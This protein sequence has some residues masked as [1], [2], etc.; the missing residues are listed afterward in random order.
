MECIKYVD[1]K[2]DCLQVFLSHHK[3]RSFSII[4]IF[5]LLLI[6]SNNLQ[7]LVM[8]NELPLL[9]CAVLMTVVL[10]K[11]QKKYEIKHKILHFSVNYSLKL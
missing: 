3:I 4:F 10:Q 9:Y 11:S 2:Q 6:G 8:I 7:V 5:S 1:R